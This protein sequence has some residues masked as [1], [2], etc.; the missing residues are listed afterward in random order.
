MKELYSFFVERDVEKEVTTTRKRGDKTVESTKTVTE[1]K[2]DRV[3]FTKPTAA[4]KEQAEFFYGQKFNE[5]INAGFLTRAMLRKKMGDIGGFSS[6]TDTEDMGKALLEHAEATRII[7]FYG[8]RKDLTEEEKAEKEQAQKDALK[9]RHTV[10]QYESSLNDQFSQ[11]ADTKADQKIIEWFVFNFSYYEDEQ[12]E[13]K[14]LFPIFKG[15]DYNEKRE[16]Y[17]ELCEEEESIPPKIRAIF[18]DGFQTLA[19]VASIW[20]NSLGKD[21]E[22]IQASL[23]ELF[24]TA[25]QDRV[26]S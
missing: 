3:V 21:Q 25:K 10:E 13:K 9:A 2:K 23:D 14:E 5:F 16:Y 22:S 8:E 4:H 11:T 12:G 6:K 18:Q 15:T 1:K 7:E 24:P 26:S 19:R 17:L 20:Y